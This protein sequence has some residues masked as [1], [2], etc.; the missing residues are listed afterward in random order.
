MRKIPIISEGEIQGEM[1]RTP[2][3]HR[4]PMKSVVE[5]NTSEARTVELKLHSFHGS[6]FCHKNRHNSLFINRNFNTIMFP[7]LSQYDADLNS[8]ALKEVLEAKE[9][10][11]ESDL[12]GEIKVP[13][14][15]YYGVQSLRG[16]YNY[17]I[18][19][20]RLSSYRNFIKAF[21]MIKKAC[22][23][24]NGRLGLINKE[25]VD[26]VSAACD[27]VIEGKLDSSFIVDMIQGGAGTSTNMNAN[28][29][30]ANRA[31][32]I[33]GKNKGEYTIVSPNDH[34]NKC[35]STNDTYPSSGKLGMYLDHFELVAELEKLIEAFEK[36][37]V[38]FK[39]VLKMG[40]TQLQDAVP[41]TLGQEFHAYA[42]TLRESLALIKAAAEPLKVQ[43]LGGTAIGTGAAAY[44][45]LNFHAALK[46]TAARLSQI[47]NDLRL[48]GS[49]PRCGLH[50][51]NLPPRAPGSSIMPGKVNPV[52]PEVVNQTCFQIIGAD[53][54][55]TMASEAGQLELNVMEPTIIYNCFN[56][57]HYF[58]RA[59]RILRELCVDMITANPEHTKTMVHN[60]IGIVTCLLP[61]IG[62]K[63][64]TKAAKMALESGKSVGQ[65]LVEL[66][67]CTEE[68][69][70]KLLVP[71]DMIH[72][73]YNS[74]N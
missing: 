30:I 41:M 42:S 49:G 57:I 73:K 60:S 10:R 19:G 36:K 32:E 38:E 44:G 13:K 66:G 1:N 25:I 11:T 7:L 69:V 6:P 55:C 46:V 54:A 34:I 22:I 21:G 48:M 56:S 52:I 61:Y 14:D 18:T 15:A 68:E 43:N 71:E 31:L 67:L 33:L 12:L 51:I 27:D 20:V 70:K 40:R 8:S 9:F 2:L 23:I 74:K 3:H 17:N 65:V 26:A 47:C 5:K 64:C 59:F 72:P 63:N 58:T 24:A 53:T 45:M 50:E 35:Q 29:V 4:I 28:E 39:D 62:Y 16:L 37:A